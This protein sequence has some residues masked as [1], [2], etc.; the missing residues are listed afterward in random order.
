MYNQ[1]LSFFTAR[2][3]Y[4]FCRFLK[5][6]CHR[7]HYLSFKIHASRF[8]YTSEKKKIKTQSHS[9][10]F[11]W[12]AAVLKMLNIHNEQLLLKWISLAGGLL[13]TLTETTTLS[14]LRDWH[15]NLAKEGWR[16]DHR[17]VSRL[18]TI[19][20]RSNQKENTVLIKVANGVSEDRQPCQQNN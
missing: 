9:M 4:L 17:N 10:L 12:T 11:C 3:A 8:L 5:L 20:W 2:S 16:T 1:L 6:P 15:S 7:I 18:L 19:N 14:E 13:I